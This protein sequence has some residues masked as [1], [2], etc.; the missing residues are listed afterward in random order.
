MTCQ[1][2]P[3]LPPTVPP[4]LLPAYLPACPPALPLSLPVSLSLSRSLCRSQDGPDH[5]AKTLE[6]LADGLGY[7]A[8]YARKADREGRAADGVDLGNQM[9]VN[10]QAF[11]VVRHTAVR[12][13]KQLDACAATPEQR[14]LYTA[15]R[16]V[17]LVATLRHLATGREVRAVS[18]HVSADF[19]NPDV[20]VA[21]VKALLTALSRMTPRLPALVCGD[22]NSTPVS[23]VYEL[24][25]TGDLPDDHDDARPQD[26]AVPPLELPGDWRRGARLRSAYAAVD[27]EEPPRTTALGPPHAFE[28]CLDYVWHTAELEPVAVMPC[29]PDAVLAGGL[30]NAVVPSDHVPLGAAFRWAAA[31]PPDAAP[32]AGAPRPPPHA[33]GS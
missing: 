5:H 19:R 10:R 26:P 28:A 23:G 24:L 22:F 30:P 16:Q 3:S 29:P 8:L 14:A 32:A 20:Q 31:P 12:F 6:R 7:D 33:A 13:A 11:A 4:S 9:L 15:Q 1:T 21:Q 18:V 17:A 25:S 27:G 2:P